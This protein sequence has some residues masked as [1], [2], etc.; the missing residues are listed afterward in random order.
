MVVTRVAWPKAPAEQKPPGKGTQPRVDVADLAKRIDGLPHRLLAY[1]GAGGFPVVV[2]VAVAGHDEAGPCLSVS[3]GLLPPGGRRA[4]L[5][6][7]SFEPQCVRLS[8][9]ML[10][11]ANEGALR[12]PHT[13]KGLAALSYQSLL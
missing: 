13:S 3:P 7:R 8:I 9:R 6:A 5:L 12:P 4:G 2:P 11:V 10:T 1:R